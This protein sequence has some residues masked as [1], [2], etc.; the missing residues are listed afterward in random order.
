M[1]QLP[2]N[3]MKWVNIIY[4][5]PEKAIDAMYEIAR[6]EIGV[7]LMSVP[8]IFKHVARSRGKGAN[9]FWET[10]GKAGD[11]MDRDQMRLRV[12]L[13]G[14]TSAK[15]LAYEEKVL[16]E[17]AHETG[18]SAREASPIDESWIMSADS[19]SVFFV[20]GL[21]AS[22]GLSLD[23]LDQGLK[24]G[25]EI[26]RLK[27]KYT[28]PLGEDYG[29]SGWFQAQEMGHMSYFEFLT[30][31]NVEDAETLGKLAEECV[32]LDIR[33][34]GYTYYQDPSIL[35]PKWFNYHLLYKKIKEAFDP[36]GVSNPPKPL[37][38][39]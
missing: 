36:A 2:P 4:P 3:R 1:L 12:L 7:I 22:V 15:Q 21:E 20:G 8:P 34:G 38:L 26:A 37:R 33:M 24:L 6:H 27:K 11:T 28:P 16:M 19:I 35:G 18:G 39:Q 9:A 17:I 29:Y 25:K 13:V 30:F 10:W 32:D 14:F 5:S 31:G 23:S